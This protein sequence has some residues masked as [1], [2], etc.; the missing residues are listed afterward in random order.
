[1]TLNATIAPPY[2]LIYIED[3]SGGENP[4]LDHGAVIAATASCVAVGC[5]SD[6]D[7]PTRFTLGVAREV[8]PGTRPAFEGRI[9]TPTRMVALRTALLQTILAAPVTHEETYIRVWV[10]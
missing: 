10:N 9:I 1:M 4:A 2:A 6:V 3:P 7:G 8:D 5:Q